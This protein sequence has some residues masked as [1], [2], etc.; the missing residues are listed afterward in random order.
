MPVK[1][2]YYFIIPYLK[3]LKILYYFST[4]LLDKNAWESITPKLQEK[5]KTYDIKTTLHKCNG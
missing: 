3:L 1:V 4:L 5:F 2:G